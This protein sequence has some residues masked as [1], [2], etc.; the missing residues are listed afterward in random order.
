[1]EENQIRRVPVV[2][3]SGCCCGIIS[4]ADIAMCA[5]ESQAA[6]WSARSRRIR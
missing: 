6:S 1:M 5:S 4:Q 3:A 2:D